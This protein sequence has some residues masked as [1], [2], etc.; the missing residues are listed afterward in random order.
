MGA[1]FGRDVW[2]GPRKSINLSDWEEPGSRCR[3]LC[4]AFLFRP[5][6]AIFCWRAAFRQDA[7]PS[8][9]PIPTSNAATT[10]RVRLS[11]PIDLKPDATGA[12]PAEQIRELLRRAEEN[13]M[14]NDKQLRDYTYIEREE[15]RDLDGHGRVKKT[16]T[17]TSEVLEIYGGPVERLTAK[18]DKPL[19]AGEAKKKTTRS[20]R[21]ST[22]ANRNR[23]KPAA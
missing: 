17:R 4:Y 19:P 7:A 14:A 6:F 5:I 2:S 13:D 9:T 22:N 21:S 18:D 1:R 12:V 8:S 11:K 23:K 3:V 10:S 16:E 20:R 15:R